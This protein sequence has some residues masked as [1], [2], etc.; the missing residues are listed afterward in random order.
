M[1][2]EIHLKYQEKITV[3]TWADH[4]HFNRAHQNSMTADE[5][6]CQSAASIRQFPITH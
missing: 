1:A 3:S 2:Q 4:Y 6:V 5:G